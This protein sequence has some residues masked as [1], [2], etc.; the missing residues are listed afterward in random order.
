[1]FRLIAVFI[2]VSEIIYFYFSAFLMGAIAL[3]YLLY[4]WFADEL[5]GVYAG[6]FM[7]NYARI[8]RP[9]TGLSVKIV[10]LFILCIPIIIRFL[11]LYV[12][13]PIF[14][15]EVLKGYR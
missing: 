8:L 7:N 11:I 2:G 10:A 15:P 13:L 9:S 4:I 12:I 6:K 3:V 5:A 14:A 1:M